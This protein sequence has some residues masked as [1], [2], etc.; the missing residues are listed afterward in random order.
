MMF[1]EFV[2]PSEEVKAVGWHQPERFTW[3]GQVVHR[4]TTKNGKNVVQFL[5]YQTDEDDFVIKTWD[6]RLLIAVD[7]DRRL[8][9]GIEAALASGS[10]AN[11]HEQ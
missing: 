11:G 8:A 4:K 9:A 3:P 10:T 7:D 6:E 2:M 5:L 1:S